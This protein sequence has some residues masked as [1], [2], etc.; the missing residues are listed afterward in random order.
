MA[1]SPTVGR[2]P[3]T[4]ATVEKHGGC[5]SCRFRLAY[6]LITEDFPDNCRVTVD[7]ERLGRINDRLHCLEYEEGCGSTN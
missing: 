4:Q 6:D 5:I 3:V 1:S 7:C 2:K